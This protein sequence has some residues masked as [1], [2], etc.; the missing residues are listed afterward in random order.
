MVCSE[1]LEPLKGVDEDWELRTASLKAIPPL[2]TQSVDLGALDA[3]LE[4]LHVP[5]GTQSADLRSSVVRVACAT[6]SQIA[7]EHGRA[8]SPLAIG[9]LPTVRAISIADAERAPIRRSMRHRRLVT[10]ITDPTHTGRAC[11]W[12]LL[13]NYYVSVKAISQ[14]SE[15]TATTLV[16]EVPTS[17]ALAVLLQFSTDSHHQT[18]R[19]AADLM[20]TA[21]RNGLVLAPAQVRACA[22][23]WW[24]V[25][26]A[27][28]DSDCA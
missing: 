20:A 15:T 22:R 5:F 2:L 23:S 12:Q 19:G 13:K 28:V 21:I 25:H 18:R 9:V 10:R 24:P 6:L 16:A 14:T 4:G 26:G 27:F 7:K 8:I 3:L 11:V 1:R 17:G